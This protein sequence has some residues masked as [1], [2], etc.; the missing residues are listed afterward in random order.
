MVMANVRQLIT[1][2]QREPEF[3]KRLARADGPQS[4]LAILEEE[5]LSF[6][7]GEFEEAYRHLWASSQTEEIARQLQDF[8]QWWELL[9]QTPWEGQINPQEKKS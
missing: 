5:N 6:T 1:R 2:T 4:V 7:P 8:R 9:M 3:R